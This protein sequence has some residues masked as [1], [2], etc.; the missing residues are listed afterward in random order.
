[1]YY[2]SKDEPLVNLLYSYNDIKV[3]MAYKEFKLFLE[4]LRNKAMQTCKTKDSAE[5]RATWQLIDKIF[6]HVENLEGEVINKQKDR[7]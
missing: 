3:T 7:I 2:I 6:G 5:A 1:M 4:D